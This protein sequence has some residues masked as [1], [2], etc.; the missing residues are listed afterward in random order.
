ME[1][2]LL[3]YVLLF[4]FVVGEETRLFD[5]FVG[6]VGCEEGDSGE[7]VERERRKRVE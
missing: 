5:T 2:H 1:P 7:I 4:R 3:L 6:R